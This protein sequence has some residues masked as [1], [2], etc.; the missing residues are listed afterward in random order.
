MDLPIDGKYAFTVALDHIPLGVM[1]GWENAEETLRMISEG[2]PDYLVLNF[3]IIKKYKDLIKDKT[4][5]ILRIDGSPS[6]LVED[7][8]NASRY[9]LLYT[10]D[11]AIR[12]GASAVIANILVGGAVEMQTVIT[13]AKIASACLE[14]NLPFIISAIPSAQREQNEFEVVTFGAR[15]AAEIG[16]DVVNTYFSGNLKELKQVISVCPMPIWLAGGSMKSDRDTINRANLALQAG[17]AGICFGRSIWQSKSP[18]SVMKSLKLLLH[19]SAS[20]EQSV[21]ALLE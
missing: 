16:A 17:C 11:D 10:V 12:V 6:Y 18:R 19:N 13:A 7:W 21:E 20:L 8:R 4:K 15:L 14:R 2:E 3:G 1:E 5:A 9:D